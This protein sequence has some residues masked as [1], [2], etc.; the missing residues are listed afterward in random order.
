MQVL[1]SQIVVCLHHMYHLQMD[2]ILVIQCFKVNALL[3]LQILIIV[4]ELDLQHVLMVIIIKMEY[5]HNVQIQVEQ[6]HVQ[7]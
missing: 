7:M 5:V 6:K 3:A 1:Q 2:V 4:T